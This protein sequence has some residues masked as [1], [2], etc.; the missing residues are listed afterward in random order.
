M[1]KIPDGDWTVV[2]VREHGFEIVHRNSGVGG[3]GNVFTLL[4]EDIV[5]ERVFVDVLILG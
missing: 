5:E 1:S 2:A 3:S 4:A